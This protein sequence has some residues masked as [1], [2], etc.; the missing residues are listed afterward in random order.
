MGKSAKESES[1]VSDKIRAARCLL[2]NTGHVKSCMKSGGPSSKAKYKLVT[3]S[4]LVPQGK[5]EKS[6]VEGSE[7]VSETVRLQSVRGRCFVRSMPDDV[8]FA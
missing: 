2:S 3:D 4:E 7:I 1:L 5:G 6:P 8:P